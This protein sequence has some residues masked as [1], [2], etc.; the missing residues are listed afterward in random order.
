MRCL[1]TCSRTDEV[2]PGDRHQGH[3]RDRRELGVV[4][5]LAGAG[6]AL[7]ISDHGHGYA[8]VALFGALT[9]LAAGAATVAFQATLNL[10]GTMLAILAFVILGNPSAGGASPTEMLPGLWRVVGPWLPPGACASG[11][12]SAS[13]F[14]DA[15]IARPLIVLLVWIILGSALALAFSRP[16]RGL[17]EEEA[18]ASVG[19]AAA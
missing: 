7:G 10:G 12:R 11:V 14:P 1:I 3:G 6:I 4:L 9:V 16:G 19:A 8:L 15:S 2:R 13:Y 5:G 18:E 17:T